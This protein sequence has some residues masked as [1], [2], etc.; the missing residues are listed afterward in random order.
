MLVLAFATNVIHQARIPLVAWSMV[1]ALLNMMAGNEMLNVAA[2]HVSPATTSAARC[3][4]AG[5]II[6]AVSFLALTYSVGLL[7]SGHY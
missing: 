4:A 7:P 2:I 5:F 3:A 1:A 6:S